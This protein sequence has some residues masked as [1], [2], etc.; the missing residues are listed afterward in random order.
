M[1]PLHQQ[2]QPFPQ[3]QQ[4][5]QA[6]SSEQQQQQ[7]Q[8]DPA[9]WQNQMQAMMQRMEQATS[10]AE[11][12]ADRASRGSAYKSCDDQAPKQRQNTPPIIGQLSFANLAAHTRQSRSQ[13]PQ[14]AA[15]AGSQQP[16]NN[17][18]Q[19]SRLRETSQRESKLGSLLNQ[20][21]RAN[22]LCT[23]KTTP[24]WQ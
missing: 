24:V 21:W 5:K 8:H 3:L 10:R 19:L 15:A 22:L 11:E 1:P 18:R 9:N 2:Q 23:W 16:P 20:S 13:S 17:R 12:A 14:A 7:Q 4:Q 6:A